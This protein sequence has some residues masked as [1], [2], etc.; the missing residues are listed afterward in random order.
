MIGVAWGSGIRIKK[1]RWSAPIHPEQLFFQE[2]K[3][4]ASGL[5]RAHTD[6]V[7]TP[8]TVQAAPVEARYS[9]STSLS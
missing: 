3:A 2:Q 9:V 4:T 6:G 5:R 7:E 1:T 8:R